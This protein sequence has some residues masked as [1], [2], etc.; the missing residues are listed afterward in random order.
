MDSLK[1][2]KLT[3]IGLNQTPIKR[4]VSRRIEKKVVPPWYNRKNTD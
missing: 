4:Q 1:N 2:L 3:A